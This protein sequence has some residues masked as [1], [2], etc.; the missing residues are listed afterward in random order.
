LTEVAVRG[1]AKVVLGGRTLR[2]LSVIPDFSQ[3]VM[4]EVSESEPDATSA[5]PRSFGHAA[6]ASSAQEHYLL[7]SQDDGRAMT[8]NVTRNPEVLHA[9]GLRYF[10]T[11]LIFNPKKDL[12]GEVPTNMAP[13]LESAILVKVEGRAAGLFRLKVPP[14][15]PASRT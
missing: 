14:P 12:P 4:V 3:M 15:M 8:A 13:W 9:G 6:V 10:R 7:V 5:F 11:T 2:I 1:G